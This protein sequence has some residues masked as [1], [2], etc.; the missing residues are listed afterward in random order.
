MDNLKLEFEYALFLYKGILLHLPKDI[1]YVAYDC[2]GQ[3]V[4]SPDYIEIVDPESSDTGTAIKPDNYR[5]FWTR[6][7]MEESLGFETSQERV[8]PLN[9]LEVCAYLQNQERLEKLN[10]PRASI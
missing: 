6:Y 4:A 3:L 5:I 7:F 8:A 2:D 1:K 10:G 9:I